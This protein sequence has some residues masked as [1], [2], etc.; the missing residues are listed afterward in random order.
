V[1]DITGQKILDESGDKITV[2]RVVLD[3]DRAIYHENF[4][5]DK[6]RNLLKAHGDDIEEEISMPREQWFVL[7]A[8]KPGVSG[9]SLAK[10]Y[11]LEELTDYQNR[12]RIE[13]DKKRGFCFIKTLNDSK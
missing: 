12:S 9:R 11:N 10:E 6:L 8:R 4:N 5:L 3:L 2:T 13:I 7:R 1:Y